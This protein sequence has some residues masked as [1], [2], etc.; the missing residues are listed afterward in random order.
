MRR[1]RHPDDFHDACK[2]LGNGKGGDTCY[3]LSTKKQVRWSRGL[4]AWG[5]HPRAAFRPQL[6][7]STSRWARQ[8]FDEASHILGEKLDER[9]SRPLSC[10]AFDEVS[11]CATGFNVTRQRT[12][13]EFKWGT[14]LYAGL[15]FFSVR[16]H[17]F[18]RSATLPGCERTVRFG[19]RTWANQPQSLRN[20]PGGPDMR[21]ATE[22]AERCS[23]ICVAK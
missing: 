19:H 17:S 2:C 22:C 11:I 6:V 18:A 3:R 20:H 12:G 5:T 15:T 9:L 7:N 14:K 10:R 13:T 23:E 16:G 8:S 1:F 21:V 4:P